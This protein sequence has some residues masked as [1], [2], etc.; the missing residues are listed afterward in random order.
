M[1]VYC[2]VCGLDEGLELMSSAVLPGARYLACIDCRNEEK[3]PRPLVVLGSKY[4]NRELA[5]EY[6]RDNR[7]LG[8]EIKASEIL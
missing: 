6:I 2:S 8:A 7:Y 5:E 1:N 4:G 3:E